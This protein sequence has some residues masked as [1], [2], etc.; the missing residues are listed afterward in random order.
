MRRRRWMWVAA[1]P[2]VLIVAAVAVLAFGYPSVAA[3]ACPRC[4]SLVEASD[5]LYVEGGLDETQHQIMIRVRSDADQRVAEFY[6]GRESDPMLLACFTDDCYRRIGGGGERGVAVLNR[7]VMLSPRGLDV[8]IASH[9]MAHVEF[10]HRLGDRAD[11]VPQWFDEGLAV[12]VSKDGRNIRPPGAGDRCKVE[13]TGALP[14]TLQDWLA[15]AT[16]DDQ[17]Y[18][19]AA[20]QTYRWLDAHGGKQGVLDLATTGWRG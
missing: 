4:F 10:D 20:C 5:G 11:G 8:V 14:V 13:P 16:A 2:V 18:A 3:T 19:K 15:A 7:A 1:G 9:E 6:G 17:M 12:I